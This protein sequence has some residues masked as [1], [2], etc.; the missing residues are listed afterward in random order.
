LPTPGSELFYNTKGPVSGLQ[1]GDG[2]YISCKPT[3]SSEEET[4]VTYDKDTSSV[5]FSNIFES[6]LFKLLIIIII[7]VVLFLILFYGISTFYSYLTSDKIKIP[8]LIEMKNL[9]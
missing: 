5:N 8:S 4:E 9:S 2:I 3:G 7:G 6:P 1:L